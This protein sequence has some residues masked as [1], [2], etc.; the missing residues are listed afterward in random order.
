M[1][2]P[3]EDDDFDERF[4]EWWESIQGEEERHP[5]EDLADALYERLTEE[6]VSRFEGTSVSLTPMGCNSYCEAKRGGRA[7]TIYCFATT[8][9]QFL[10]RFD[11]KPAAPLWGR[12]FI[13]AE[14]IGAVGAW[15]E[16]ASPQDLCA[17]FPFVERQQRVLRQLEQNLLA[18]EPALAEHTTHELTFSDWGSDSCNLWFRTKDR[19]CEVYYY[20]YNGVPD[21]RFHW[22]KCFQFGG[23]MAQVP[24]SNVRTEED[25][26]NALRAGELVSWNMHQ[27]LDAEKTTL[28]A[29]LMKQWLCDQAMPSA[30][31]RE[32]PWIVLSEMASWYEQGRGVEGEFLAS[33]RFVEEFYQRGSE[34]WPL[35][36]QVLRLISQLRD[37]GY[38]RTLRAGK[39]LFT[40]IVS[41]ARRHGLKQRMPNEQYDPGKHDPHIVFR[42]GGLLFNPQVAEGQMEVAAYLDDGERI[43]TYP[44]IGLTTELKRLLDKLQA[45]PIR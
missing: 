34:G 7:C 38:D 32:Y 11:E 17:R 30:I 3:E 5:E 19:S 39:S 26:L 42:F 13:E 29:K 44:S 31:Q 33:W 22:D 27:D 12:T 10:A 35:V 15:L 18:I 41:R 4:D 40:L 21:A 2:E 23:Q 6:V 24:N 37:A 36:S 16:G 43:T 9:Q 8:G 20:A 14:V 28:L 1:A 25:F 45:I